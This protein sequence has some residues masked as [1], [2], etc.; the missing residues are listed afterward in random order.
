[1]YIIAK[2]F[3]FQTIEYLY[4]QATKVEH[5]KR[6]KN[7]PLQIR[8]SS[9]LRKNSLGMIKAS[10]SS[11]QISS[12]INNI[13]TEKDVSVNK[14]NK[15]NIAAIFERYFNLKGFFPLFIFYN[16]S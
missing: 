5:T 14:K 7:T 3:S 13:S 11:L 15:A 2:S 16:T 10:Q 9:L 4:K 6:F 8:E 1:M 12:N